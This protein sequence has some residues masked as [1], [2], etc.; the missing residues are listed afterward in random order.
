MA[1]RDGKA[2]GGR[3]TLFMASIILGITA[4]VSIQSF[5]DNLKE[6]IRLQSKSLMGADFIIDSRQLPNERVQEIIDSLGGAKG[7]EVNFASMAAFPKNESSKLV[8]VR[9]LEGDFPLYGEIETE[10]ADAATSYI[11]N[12]GALVDATVMLQFELE[13]GD[14]IK[15]GNASLPIT[16][17]LI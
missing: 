14:I 15:I 16:G 1:W 12:E 5:S 3:L 11:S 13:V 4:L 6:N 2:S 8:R 10:P 17:T 9:G 7:M